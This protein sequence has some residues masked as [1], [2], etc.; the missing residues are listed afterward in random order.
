MPATN[1]KTE[2]KGAFFQ[3]NQ[4]S[5]VFIVGGVIVLILL[6]IGYQKLYL[7]PRA[8]KAAD[9]MYKAEEFDLIDSLQN[10]DIE[11]DGSFIGFKEIAE[12]YSNTASAHIV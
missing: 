3:D 11:G 8:G 1:N 2:K 12:E 4:K 5:I 7:E 6:Y 9:A 10:K